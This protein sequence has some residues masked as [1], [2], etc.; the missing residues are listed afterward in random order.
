M[1]ELNFGQ[2]TSTY[3][4]AKSIRF[5]TCPH[6]FGKCPSLSVGG[7]REVL[8]FRGGYPG[9]DPARGQTPI[10]LTAKFVNDMRRKKTFV[11]TVPLCIASRKF[12][13]W[14]LIRARE[15]IW[16]NDLSFIAV[17][18]RHFALP[19]F[20]RPISFMTCCQVRLT[21]SGSLCCK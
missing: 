13:A 18:Q 11:E 8:S 19:D 6:A 16:S 2:P 17:S 5:F 20:V 12:S 4:C 21:K 14:V 10:R 9:L 15:R 3:E 1:N 7:V